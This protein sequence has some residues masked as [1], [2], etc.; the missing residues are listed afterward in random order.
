MRENEQAEYDGEVAILRETMADSALESA[1]TAGRAMVVE[2]VV[3]LAL[4]MQVADS[5]LP[6]KDEASP[7]AQSAPAAL[8]EPLSQRE[9]QVLGLIAD[10]LSNTEIA[11]R[12][13]LAPTTVKVHTRHI[14][15]KLNVNSRT[16]AVAKAHMLKLL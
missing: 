2:E 6:T 16:Q 14:Y 1:W 13:F 4:K 3:A 8:V 15:E 7:L 12:L 5:P 11:E 9:R 10:G